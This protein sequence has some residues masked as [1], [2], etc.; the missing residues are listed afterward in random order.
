MLSISPSIFCGSRP[1]VLLPEVA[2]AHE[3]TALKF[4]GYPWCQKHLTISRTSLMTLLSLLEDSNE[5][6]LVYT[7]NSSAANQLSRLRHFYLLI[8]H[9]R[10]EC[11]LLAEVTFSPLGQAQ[12]VEDMQVS[13]HFI[14]THSNPPA[15]TTTLQPEPP[16]LEDQSRRLAEN[17]ST[18]ILSRLK[19]L[20][21]DGSRKLGKRIP[22][23]FSKPKRPAKRDNNRCSLNQIF[24]QTKLHFA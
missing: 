20:F 17:S 10:Q 21:P 2:T 14:S 23:A 7:P 12:L 5:A 8:P 3:M 9:S 15:S 4:W 1:Y 19:S 24:S 6:L 16:P 22:E 18:Q 11:M 13:P